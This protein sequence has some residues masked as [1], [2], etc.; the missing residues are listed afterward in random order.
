[1]KRALVVTACGALALAPTP[2]AARMGAERPTVQLSVSPARL[3]LTAPAARRITLRNTG[4]RRV[5]VEV[6]PRADWLLVVPTRLELR[7]GASGNLTLR[8]PRLQRAEPGEHRA[9]V[10]LTT[11]PLS[12]GRVDVKVRLGVRVTMRVAGR[13]VRR[14]ALGSLRL[15]SRHRTRLI[16]V[17]VANHG[18]VTITLRGHVSASLLRHG[19]P[20]AHLGTQAPAALRPGKRGLVVLGYAGRKRGLVTAILRVRLGRDTV[21]RSYRLRL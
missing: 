8:V 17:T 7:S 15:R 5:V 10:L 11:R 1:V 19:R 12:G 2:A 21:E 20:V 18:N 16:L 14:L 6:A 4:A 13:V 3:T 9:R